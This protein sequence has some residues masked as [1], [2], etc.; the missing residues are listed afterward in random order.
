MTFATGRVPHS[1]P[2]QSGCTGFVDG[3]LSGE[4]CVGVRKASLGRRKSRSSISSQAKSSFMSWFKWRKLWSRS[5]Q[6]SCPF[7]PQPAIGCGQQY[8]SE[9]L[10]ASSEVERTLIFSVFQLSGYKYSCHDWFK[11]PAWSY[12]TQTWEETHTIDSWALLQPTTGCGP[13]LETWVTSQAGNV[14]CLLR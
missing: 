2:Q 4:A 13:P 5:T 10:S 6:Q 12:R 14:C 8:A 3:Q 11:L 9:H 7:V 1:G